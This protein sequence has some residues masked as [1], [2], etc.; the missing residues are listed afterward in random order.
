MG[1]RR[2]DELL[3]ERNAFLTKVRDVPEAR[4]SAALRP[5]LRAAA[6]RFVGR[7]PRIR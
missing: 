1:A 3:G 5:R 4:P 2:D 7:A 6:L